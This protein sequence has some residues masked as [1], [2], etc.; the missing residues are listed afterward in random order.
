VNV[1]I[2]PVIFYVVGAALVVGGTVRAMTLGR[3]NPAREI[4][5]DD[6]AKNKA[7]RRHFTFGL[8]WVA[9]GLFLIG[10]TV[11]VLRTRAETS[12]PTPLRPLGASAP[13]IRLDPAR[14]TSI[15]P[16]AKP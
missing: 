4:A 14:P 3:R 12:S 13:A 5:D 11:G 7:R 16:P 8:V 1:V 15:E 6:P 9:M 10:S 2:P